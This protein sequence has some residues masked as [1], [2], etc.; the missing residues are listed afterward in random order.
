MPKL[1]TYV[2]PHS[3]DVSVE[4]AIVH[5]H[6]DDPELVCAVP[7]DDGPLIGSP[8]VDLS[9]LAGRPLAAR[10]G[11]G[12]WLPISLFTPRER[13]ASLL[14]G[15]AFARASAVLAKLARGQA[16]P[17]RESVDLDPEYEEE[18]GDIAR[19]A[20]EAEQLAPGS[21]FYFEDYNCPGMVYLGTRADFDGLAREGG[22]PK[23]VN[24]R[25]VNPEGWIDCGPEG[26]VTARPVPA[27][28]AIQHDM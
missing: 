19:G 28:W 23:A 22:L 21:L 25:R 8:D 18:M 13:C 12:A 2:L 15:E 24:P 26:I 5:I 17:N 27:H 3:T 7:V 14:P 10:C 20:H 9:D 16:V 1:Y 4:W 11:Q 6:P